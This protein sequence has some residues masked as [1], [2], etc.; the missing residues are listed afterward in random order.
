MND[1]LKESSS[2][3]MASSTSGNKRKDNLKESSS[4]FMASTM[5]VNKHPLDSPTSSGREIKEYEDVEESELLE[6]NEYQD[7]RPNAGG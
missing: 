5:S 2:D 3:F 6:S 4:D 7:A 1:N